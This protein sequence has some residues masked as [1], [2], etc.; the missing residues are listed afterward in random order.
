MLDGVQDSPLEYFNIGTGEGLS[1]FELIHAF[2]KATGITLPYKV[3]GRREGDIEKVWADSTK[4]NKVLGWKAS[5]T[6][7]ETLLSAW[8]WEKR[9]NETRKV[10]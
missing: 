5:A 1:V 4:A 3:A 10:Q 2:E 8:N 9:I 6:L 7:E